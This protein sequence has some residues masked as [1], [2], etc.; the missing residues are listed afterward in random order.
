[1]PVH[2]VRKPFAIALLGAVFLGLS[3]GPARAQ[4]GPVGEVVEGAGIKVSEGTVIHPVLGVETGFISNVFYEES[5]P[6]FSGLLRII[7]ELAMGSL[8]EERM[9]PAPEEPVRVRNYGDFAFRAELRARYEE[10]LSPEV[11]VRAQRDVALGALAQGIVFPRRTWQFGF[12]EEF[13]RETRPVNFESSEDTDRDI[14]Q[15][16]LTL[17]FKP[18]GRRLSSELR[19]ANI[20]DYFE[21]DRQQFAN[22]LMHKVGLNV[23]WQ[24]LPMTRIFGDA[25]LGFFGGFGSTSTRPSSMPLRIVAGVATALTVKTQVRGQIGFGK[26]FYETGPDFTNVTGQLQ[27]GY[28]YSPHARLA[29]FYEYD[30]HD[31]INANFYRDHGTGLKIEQQIERFSFSAG[32]ELRFRTYRGVIMEASGTT[33][34]RS[35]LIVDIPL[36]AAYNFRNWIAATLEYRFT[37]DQTDFRYIPEM[38]GPPDDPSFTRHILMAGVRAAY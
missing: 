21:S 24:W 16:T 22:R 14:N 5:S 7:G 11:D 27:L 8:P 36:T 4:D 29:A 38:G 10:Y 20:V 3:A 9:G 25:S 31:S 23:G 2:N 1:M 32:G 35:D 37:T 33:P 17:R 15:V 26:G 34:D 30:F 19:Y 13:R 18:Q 28:R 6:K 12:T